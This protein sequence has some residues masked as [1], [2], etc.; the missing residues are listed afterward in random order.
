MV[1]SFGGGSSASLLRRP[2]SLRLPPAARWTVSGARKKAPAPSS[3]RAASPRRIRWRGPFRSRGH[4]RARAIAAS[5][6][7]RISSG[8]TSWRLRRGPAQAPSRC[9]RSSTPTTIRSNP[10]PRRSRTI[11][12]TATRTGPP[13]SG[14]TSIAI[15]PVTTRRRRAWRS[16][17]IPYCVAA[18]LIV[19]L[20][21]PRS[22]PSVD[23]ILR[24]S[25]RSHPRIAACG[26]SAL[27]LRRRCAVR[28]RVLSDRFGEFRERRLVALAGEEVGDAA[29]RPGHALER[30]IALV[31]GRRIFSAFLDVKRKRRTACTKIEELGERLIAEAQDLRARE[32]IAVPP[33]VGRREGRADGPAELEGDEIPI[34]LT[35]E[36]DLEARAAKKRLRAQD[37]L[38]PVYRHASDIVAVGD[39]YHAIG[40]AERPAI[41]SNEQADGKHDARG[42]EAGFDERG[43]GDQETGRRRD[44]M[45]DGNFFLARKHGI[46]RRFE[47]A[48]RLLQ[49]GDAAGDDIVMCKHPL[50]RARLFPRE[51]PVDIG[52][53][54]L[55]AE[56]GHLRPSH[57]ASSRSSRAESPSAKVAA[58]RTSRWLMVS[59][60]TS[61]T[62]PASMG[63]KRSPS[64][65]SSVKRGDGGRLLRNVAVTVSNGCP[66]AVQKSA[67]KRASLVSGPACSRRSSSQSR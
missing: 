32:A 27:L 47:P 43:P 49:G 61:S 17:A 58:V 65:S 30:A 42:G 57:G 55:V 44:R 5:C 67:A 4:R 60:D 36:A 46:E 12:T 38:A 24:G 2:S 59:A 39:A 28:A 51:L 29:L 21:R 52:D 19:I 33:E 35:V 56:L 50:D 6:S 7:I 64:T 63:S 31:F 41:S 40:A 26:V 22:G 20:R 45:R 54:K 1:P 11:S 34:A 53:Q 62:R 15:C 16:N 18:S 13:R 66:L 9:R 3:K 14:A 48:M 8:R 23:V 37:L 25:L 10:S